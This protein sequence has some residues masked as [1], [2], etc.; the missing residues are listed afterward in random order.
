M[1]LNL[2][3]MLP[4][5]IYSQNVD[6]YLSLIHEGQSEGV[7]EILPELISKY[8]NDPGVLY[9][10]AMLTTNGMK[11]LELYS[12]II[13]KYPKSDFA[14]PASV[15]IGEYF[16]AQGLYSQAG[17]Q[18]RL[19]PREYPRIENMQSIIDMIVSSFLAIGEGD[20]V[21]YYLGIYR[22][23][24]PN[25]DFDKF[26]IDSPSIPNK[27]ISRGQLDKEPRPYVIQIGALEV[28]KM[29]ID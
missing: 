13:E 29:R 26:G 2:L 3:I 4:I 16:Y 15:K 11:S 17:M 8:P 27:K 6:M 28:Y 9:L 23:M 5:F 1:K 25:L 19:I 24:F 20:S 10:Q 21:K 14:G 12:K 22:G 7:K 18:L